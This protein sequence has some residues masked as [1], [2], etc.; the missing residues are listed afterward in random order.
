MPGCQP[1]RRRFHQLCQ[2]DPCAPPVPAAPACACLDGDACASSNA[3]PSGHACL[4]NN[5]AYGCLLHSACMFGYQPA[6]QGLIRASLPTAWIS[7]PSTFSPY[8]AYTLTPIL[9]G[10]S[11]YLNASPVSG[12]DGGGRLGMCSHRLDVDAALED[13]GLG[14]LPSV[15]LFACYL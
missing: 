12:S 13:L 10:L 1:C 3:L 2:L 8:P 7:R 5:A 11:I 9:P 4:C 15:L 14:G 6:R